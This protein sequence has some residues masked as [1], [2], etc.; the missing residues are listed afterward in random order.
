MIVFK[1]LT[2]LKFGWYGVIVTLELDERHALDE[3]F[4]TK[5]R[6]INQCN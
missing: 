3:M 4:W 1:C 5:E 2:R 6:V